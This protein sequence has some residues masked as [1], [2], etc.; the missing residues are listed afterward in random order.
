MLLF[1]S[2]VFMADFFPK[3]GRYTCTWWDGFEGVLSEGWVIHGQHKLL[4]PTL[5]FSRWWQ[6]EE[7]NMCLWNTDAP[8]SNKVK[9]WQKSLSPTFWPHPT[10]SQG[11]VMSVQCE[12]PLDE[13]TVQ[14]W[15]LYDHPN[16]KYYAL[17]INCKTGH[18]YG[19]TD[20]QMIQTLHVDA[21]G[22]PFRPGA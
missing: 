1:M 13:L 10:P 11:H 7:K 22:G 6:F 3:S 21:P 8:S 18:N 19:R 2:V 9:L 16:F 12:Q 5:D 4:H 14:V 20:R 17:F 15:I